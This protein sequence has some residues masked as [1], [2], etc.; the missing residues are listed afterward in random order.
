[1]NAIWLLFLFVP[2]VAKNLPEYSEYLRRLTTKAPSPKTAHLLDIGSSNA[3]RL[4]TKAPSVKT[5]QLLDI[6]S[7][8][9]IQPPPPPFVFPAIQLCK[10]R[11]ADGDYYGHIVCWTMVLLFAMTIVS[12]IVYQLRSILWLKLAYTR[13]QQ[14]RHR[15]AEYDDFFLP[16][17][18]EQHTNNKIT[19]V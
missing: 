13:N 3:S 5:A 9:A 6:G 11:P 4:T 19:A 18:D 2:L 1:M 16:P 8:T 15:S 7:S 17:K 14:Q 12:L 10:E